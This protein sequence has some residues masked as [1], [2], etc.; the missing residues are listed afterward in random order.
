MVY[1]LLKHHAAVLYKRMRLIFWVFGTWDACISPRTSRGGA[2]QRMRSILEHVGCGTR[3]DSWKRIR[4]ESNRRKRMRLN[5]TSFKTRGDC[6]GGGGRC[7]RRGGCPSWPLFLKTKGSLLLCLVTDPP[8]FIT[9]T[10]KRR[11]RCETEMDVSALS[12]P[13]WN[14]KPSI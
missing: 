9:P 11:W 4:K 12:G 8:L 5:F 6:F 13:V 3:V 7:G 10:T 1:S 2:V 14:V